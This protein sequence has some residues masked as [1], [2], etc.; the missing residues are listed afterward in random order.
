MIADPAIPM[1]HQEKERTPFLCFMKWAKNMADI[2]MS[3]A[4][5]TSSNPKQ[6]CAWMKW[7]IAP[8][9]LSSMITSFRE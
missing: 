4:K 9:G 3:E 6:L 5:C 7:A 8:S 1:A 2:H